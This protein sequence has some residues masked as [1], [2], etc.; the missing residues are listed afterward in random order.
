MAFLILSGVASLPKKREREQPLSDLVKWSEKL[1]RDAPVC[2][3][4]L[5]TLYREAASELRRKR[6]KKAI[7]T[8]NEGIISRG[9][10]VSADQIGEDES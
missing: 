2:K 4:I 7:K 6:R 3:Q 10:R 1:V 5:E 9:A 8:E